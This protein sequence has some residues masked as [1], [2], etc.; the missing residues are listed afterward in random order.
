MEARM[1]ALDQSKINEKLGNLQGWEFQNNSINK[2]YELKD[3][4]EAL[5]FVNKVGDEAEQ[6]DHH[7]DIFLHDWNKVKITVSTHS[8]GGVT[9]NDFQLAQKI[10]NI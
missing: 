4:K 9:D 8:A 2:E 7:P 3:F 6:M 1:Q 10:E 5:G